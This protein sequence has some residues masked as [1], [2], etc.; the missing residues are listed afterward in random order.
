MAK[1]VNAVKLTHEQ[2]QPSDGTEAAI[3]VAELANALRKV[4]ST[5]R[6]W[7]KPALDN[8]WVEEVAPAAGR[9][10][11]AYIPGKPMP[12]PSPLPSVEEM[13]EAF[14][15]LARDFRAVHPLAGE[16]FKMEANG[17]PFVGK[18]MGDTV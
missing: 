10:G 8:G 18:S 13:A 11:A 1:V 5:V 7:L 2:K 15:E 3:T 12:D 9:R 14:P 4:Q 17:A 6:R 16:V